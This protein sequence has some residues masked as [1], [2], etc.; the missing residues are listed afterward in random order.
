MSTQLIGVAGTAKALAVSK[1][2]VR[3]LIASGELHAV[4]IGRRLL[5]SESEVARFSTLGCAPR[6]EE[7]KGRGRRVSEFE[8][9]RFVARR[10]SCRFGSRAAMHHKG[11]A[12]PRSAAAGKW[13]DVHEFSE[14]TSK[15]LFA[16]VLSRPLS[17]LL[18]SADGSH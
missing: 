15:L 14:L 4:R 3:R 1:D 16:A 11:V 13:V 5:V 12:H 2:T 9:W 6:S 8:A 7:K 18:R 10:R 17:L